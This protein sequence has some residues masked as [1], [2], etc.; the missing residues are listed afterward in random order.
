MDDED[1]IE[2]KRS[3]RIYVSK[4]FQ[5]G[6]NKDKE[7]RYISR[8][9]DEEERSTFD[10]VDGEIVIRATHGDKVQVKAVVTSDDHSIR[11]LTLQSF[12]I[13]KDGARPNEQYGIN[14]R[15]HEI[16][17]LVEFIRLVTNI[18][19]TTPG[20]LRIDEAALAQLDLDDA[21]RT[22]LQQNPAALRHIAESQVSAGDIVAVAYR[23]Q[24]LEVFDKLLRDSDYF[25]GLVQSRFNGKEESLW[26]AFFEKNRWIFGYGLF[27]LSATGFT[28]KK[29]EQL[30]AG[31]T[32]ATAGKQADALLR[33]GGRIGAVCLVEIK[34]HR[35][36]LLKDGKGYRSGTW[37]PSSELTGAVAQSQMTVDAMERHLHQQLV[38][39]DEHG[40]PTG[41][42]AVIA[43]PRAVVVCGS[44]SEF[45]TPHGVSHERFR[46]FEL[47]RRHLVSPDVITFD[48][49]Y[50]RARLISESSPT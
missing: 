35:T 46:C 42:E 49:L 33:T 13:Y 43:R 45:V 23:R 4:P 25:D 50:E 5:V 22:W 41:E 29:L 12:R 16:E 31:A 39:T 44:L 19:V 2:K 38:V 37:Q 10:S 27:H 40:D 30:V 32:I 15:E 21:A 11:Q 20:K 3:D 17:R 28:D 14:L 8:V 1:Y 47:Y 36:L 48:E 34:K 7:A 18:E 9:F 6:L 26:Q 24:Q